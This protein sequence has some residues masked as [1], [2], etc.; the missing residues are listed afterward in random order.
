VLTTGAD[1]YATFTGLCPDTQVGDILYR[2]TEVSTK[3]GYSL[4]TGYAF[5]GALSEQSDLDVSFT[6]VNQPEFTLPS[7]GGSGFTVLSALAAVLG[8]AAGT[9]L[10]LC[11]KKSED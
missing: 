4:L 10:L 5:E 1:G 6:V 9:I 11:K 2:I 7:T 3:P 8:I